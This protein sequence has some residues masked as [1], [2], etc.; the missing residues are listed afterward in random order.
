MVFCV[1]L[2]FIL[3][4]WTICKE[5]SFNETSNGKRTHFPKQD[6]ISPR[7]TSSRTTSRL[8]PISRKLQVTADGFESFSSRSLSSSTDTQ[9]LVAV[10]FSISFIPG[11]ALLRV[12]HGLVLLVPCFL[13]G[14]RSCHGVVVVV[15]VCAFILPSDP[16]FVQQSLS[17]KS[18]F[19]NAL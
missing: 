11:P 17:T 5:S 7:V 2:S 4:A 15:L 10:A 3:H 1:I 18:N 16:D 19:V 9:L 6:G 8:E 12:R 14:R 13:A